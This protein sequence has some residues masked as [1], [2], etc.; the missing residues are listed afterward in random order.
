MVMDHLVSCFSPSEVLANLKWM[1]LR[2]SDFP[3]INSFCHYAVTMQ[4]WIFFCLVKIDSFFH[5]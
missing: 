2:F 5:P 1:Q 3:N 4:V